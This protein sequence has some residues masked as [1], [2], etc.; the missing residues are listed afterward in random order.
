VL[1]SLANEGQG[2]RVAVMA[3]RIVGGA[4]RRNRA[5][6]LLRAAVQPFLPQMRQD[7]D[8]L[9]MA[10]PGIREANSTQ[11]H[12]ALDGL[13]AKARLLKPEE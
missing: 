4:V 11:V 2:V 6:R 13:L 5:K 1:R 8:L 10:R 7:H 3:G 9:L 12:Q